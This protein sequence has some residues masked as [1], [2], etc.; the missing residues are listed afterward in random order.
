MGNNQTSGPSRG[1]RV[2]SYFKCRCNRAEDPASARD[3]MSP[4]VGGI[5]DRAK[6]D[7]AFPYE[8]EGPRTTSSPAS[9]VQLFYARKFSTA[10][11]QDRL[12]CASVQVKFQH[13]QRKWTWNSF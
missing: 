13:S 6:D 12:L 5:G 10:S 8:M 9:I 7:Q 2:V 4:V 1:I 11:R 3:R